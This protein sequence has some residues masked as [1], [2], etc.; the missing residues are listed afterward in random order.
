[1]AGVNLSFKWKTGVDLTS[2]SNRQSVF[3]LLDDEGNIIFAIY[4]ELPIEAVFRQR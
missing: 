4:P 3:K 2:G 1:M